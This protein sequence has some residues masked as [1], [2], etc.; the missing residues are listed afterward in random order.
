[1]ALQYLVVFVQR[2]SL[3]DGH[4]SFGT[5]KPLF[6][7]FVHRLGPHQSSK[8][9]HI[10]AASTWDVKAPRSTVYLDTAYIITSLPQRR[11]QVLSWS[12]GAQRQNRHASGMRAWTQEGECC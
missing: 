7:I 6:D 3:A 12:C 4:C 11:Q 2:K 9:A 8:S 10:S 1:M 5:Q